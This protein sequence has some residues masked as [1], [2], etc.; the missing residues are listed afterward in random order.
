VCSYGELRCL[1]LEDGKREWAD[2]TATGTGGK[3]LRWANAFLVAN[4]DRFFLFNEQGDL[5]IAKLTPKGYK[6]IDKAHILDPTG[7]LAG[8]FTRPRMVLWSHPAFANKAM[9][10]R[11]DKEIV[12]VSL[13]K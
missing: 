5:I 11:N 4:G 2:L 1:N 8:N 7:Q 10:A 9:Y 3:T 6:E 12:A 13:A